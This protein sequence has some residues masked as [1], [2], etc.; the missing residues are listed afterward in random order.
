[1]TGE[2]RG[3][4][5]LVTGSSRGIG[6][7]IAVGLARRGADVVINY[8]KRDSDAESVADEVR[9]TGRRAVT[10]RANV[11]E[12]D[13]ITGMFDRIRDEFGRLDFLVCNA[14]AGMQGTL[15]ET[16]LKAWDLAMNVNARSLLLCAQAALPLMRTAGGGRILATTARIAVERAFP[17]YGSVAASK[18]A[19]Q[20]LT[21]YLSVEFAPYRISVN[22]VSPGVVD[23]EALAYFREGEAILA[24]A[25]AGTPTGRTTAPCDV[26]ALVAFLC[27]EGA[28]QITGQTI[29]IDGGYTRVFV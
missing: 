10:I 8:R 29:E 2:F 9:S 20:A 1:M 19:L 28:A 7:E 21:V 11:A 24:R 23:T 4:V 12:P 16:T 14:A 5:A 25:E 22:A 13:A 17:H 26:A 3:K 27:S 15:E 18:A 6:R